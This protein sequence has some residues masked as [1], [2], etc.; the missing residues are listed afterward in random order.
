VEDAVVVKTTDATAADLHNGEVSVWK[1]N[2]ASIRNDEKLDGTNFGKDRKIN[3]RRFAW[4]K[5]GEENVE[6]EAEH[7]ANGELKNGA[8]MLR[9]QHQSGDEDMDDT[10]KS[11]LPLKSLQ[12]DNQGGSERKGFQQVNREKNVGNV[13]NKNGVREV[14]SPFQH[15]LHNDKENEDGNRH[16]SRQSA[17]INQHFVISTAA[18]KEA[19]EILKMD[20]GNSKAKEQPPSPPLI[21]AEVNGKQ[22]AS[23]TTTT[24]YQQQQRK[25]RTYGGVTVDVI[26]AKLGA[27]E[28]K[29]R[30]EAIETLAW[31]SRQSGS[32]WEG[33]EFDNL[34]L[35]LLE[36]CENDD[37]GVVAVALTVI[38]TILKKF[39]RRFSDYVHIELLTL[40]LLETL[41]DPKHPLQPALRLVEQA[42]DLVSTTTIPDNMFAIFVTRVDTELSSGN[43]ARPPSQRGIIMIRISLKCLAT[44]MLRMEKLQLAEYID[45]ITPPLVKCLN[46]ANVMVRQSVIQCFVAMH[47]VAGPSYMEHLSG[48]KDS[49]RRL[50]K[51]YVEKTAKA[52]QSRS[53]RVQNK[54]TN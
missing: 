13:D 54:S 34:F 47:A 36:S 33:D 26:L 32:I 31:L 17:S 18:V 23:A 10:K 15:Q 28:R 42:L 27:D 40:S 2:S 44:L 5:E 19:E 7:T 51:I 16:H 39:P 38:V 6:T 52:R 43:N 35:G 37:S 53:G 3:K 4:G 14:S 50:I 25:T 24:R 20:E 1:Q 49:Q 22:S 29:S 21:K 46:H 9:D 45:R 48:L 8:T 41:R 12:A 30:L 11:H